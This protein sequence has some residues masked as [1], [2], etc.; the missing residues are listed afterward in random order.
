MERRNDVVMAMAEDLTNDEPGSRSTFEPR[1]AFLVAAYNAAA[2]LPACLKGITAQHPHEVLVVDDGSTDGAAQVAESWEG[3]EVVRLDENRGVA[4]ARN[5]ALKSL[6]DAEFVA[7][8]DSDIELEEGWLEALLS[9]C[10][11]SDY[12]AACGRAR[13]ADAGNHWAA[14]L[15]EAQTSRRFGKEGRELDPPWREVM[16]FNYLFKREVFERVGE[17][18]PRFRTNAEDSDFFFRCAKEGLR[19]RYVPEAK[20][21]HRYPPPAFSSWLR[22]NYRNGFFTIQ[23][24][25]KQRTPLLKMKI[26]KAACLAGVFLGTPL[27]AA[28]FRSWLPVALALLLL[29]GAGVLQSAKIGWKPWFGGW[30]AILG[31]LAK[32]LGEGAGLI[33]G[34]RLPSAE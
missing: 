14:T 15:D 3:V 29:L 11:W 27:A 9:K 22:R 25:L 20:A 5:E 6:G 31:W 13:A 4:V 32:G 23:F 12:A 18:D 16:Y 30:I 34:H 2:V 33:R 19:F 24:H 28:V 21:L 1:V 8:V 10:D 17:F 26:L 7:F